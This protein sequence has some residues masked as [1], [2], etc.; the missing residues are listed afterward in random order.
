MK[1]WFAA[2]AKSFHAYKMPLYIGR[3]DGAREKKQDLRV[4]K[5]MVL[6]LIISLHAVR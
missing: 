1:V 3:T 2:D 6:P 4:L 5:N